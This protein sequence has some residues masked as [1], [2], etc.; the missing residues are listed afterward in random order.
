MIAGSL[1]FISCPVTHRSLIGDANTPTI[2]V[3]LG[4]SHFLRDTARETP[5]Q[6]HLTSGVLDGKKRINL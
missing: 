5:Q 4:V 3:N 2:R 6:K 1:M